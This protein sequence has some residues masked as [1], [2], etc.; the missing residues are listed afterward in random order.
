MNPNIDILIG[1]VEQL[2]ELVDE[3]VFVG[4][5]ATGLLITDKAAPPIRI[6][7]DVDAIVQ[8][9][10]RGDYYQFSDKLRAQGFSEDKSDDAP[11]CRWK[12]ADG[13]L[14][15]VM[16]IDPEVLGF[17]NQW[18]EP[19]TKHALEHLLP[20]GKTIKLISAPYFLITKLDAFN[21]RGYND[22][23]LSHDIEDI[24]AVF[25]GR[26]ELVDDVKNAEEE[27]VTELSKRFS[28]LLN[29][30]R[31]IEAVPGHMPADTISQQRVSA[32]FTAMALIAKL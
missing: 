12:S 21:G 16:P 14:L 9:M 18:Y 30:T 19:A 11:I 6:T 13:I 1:A 4:G 22:Y 29:D 15:D 8:V 2:G 7:K 26:S 3:M 10:S 20:S 24:V 28:D 31:F 17:G 5:C 32:V 27:L 25:D 23:L